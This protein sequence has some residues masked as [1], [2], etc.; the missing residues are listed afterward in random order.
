[1]L[2]VCSVFVLGTPGDPSKFINSTGGVT[3]TIGGNSGIGNFSGNVYASNIV[4]NISGSNIT[5]GTISANRIDNSIARVSDIDSSLV[6]YYN[7]INNFTQNLTNNKTCFYNS[8][9]LKIQCDYTINFT[10]TND[11]I[12]IGI[13]RTD[14]QKNDTDIRSNLSTKL[15]QSQA[16]ALYYPLGSNPS[17]Y[18]T[19]TNLNANISSLSVVYAT[20]INLNNNISALSSIYATITNLNSN[21]S[22]L[23]S[24]Y[25]TITNLN[26]NVTSLRNM[27]TSLANN[28][29]AVSANLSSNVT[30]LRNVDS[31]LAQ[32]ISYRAT[33]G[34]CSDGFVLMNLTNTSAQCVNMTI[35]TTS[36][37]GTY[38]S[39]TVIPIVIVS[40]G[41]VTGISSVTA[42]GD[43][44]GITTAS[45]SGLQGGCTSGVCTLLIN[46]TWLN[47]NYVTLTNFN[48]NMSALSLNITSL[49]GNLS[50]N[51]T[52][53]NTLYSMFTGNT[54]IWNA[55]AGTGNC[56][57]GTVV[58]NT[59][60]NGV[61]CVSVG[62]V[63]TVTS[64]STSNPIL[65]GTITSSG[66][67]S[68]NDSYTDIKYTNKTYVDSQNS[69]MKSYSDTTF[70][71]KSGLVTAVGNWTADK[72]SYNTTTQ[73]GVLY[74]NKTYVDSQNSSMK[75][76]VDSVNTAQNNTI[77]SVVT[78]LSNEASYRSGNDSL[79]NTQL[80]N[81][82]SRLDGRINATNGNL[83]SN[84]SAL[85]NTDSS[86]A[87][88][89][90]NVK[91]NLSSNSTRMDNIQNNLSSNATK[92]NSLQSSFDGNKTI[93]DAKAGTNTSGCGVGYVVQNVSTST[94]GVSVQC[95]IAT[96][97][98]PYQN[99]AAGWTN[100]STY[101]ITDLNVS[102]NALINFTG[103]NGSNTS[104][105]AGL[106]PDSEKSMTFRTTQSA[107]FYLGSGG[108]LNI[109]NRSGSWID[110]FRETDGLINTRY[111]GTSA[112]WYSAFNL[113]NN[114]TNTLSSLATNVSL[115]LDSDGTINKSQVLNWDAAC[116]HGAIVAINE[117]ATYC[118]GNLVSIG[119]NVSFNNVNVTGSFNATTSVNT[120]LV[121]TVDVNVTGCLFLSG[122]TSIGSVSACE[123]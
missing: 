108:Y 61:Q 121:N 51:A 50:G 23:S 64:V 37:S 100:D 73:N 98:V 115:K 57:S 94:G 19:V 75:S 16:D 45:D 122:N 105:Y 1:M 67:I 28:I 118:D 15:N 91:N 46:S 10:D 116:P 101:T 92:L 3:A 34:T 119:E 42:T 63:G 7:S 120:P 70:Q 49:Q 39:A 40:N 27:D 103:N 52:L 4:G 9:S 18:A 11:T 47:V 68:F 59:T 104:I 69:S 17:N 99:S 106:N 74:T 48:N 88:N 32:N 114:H 112:N 60:T 123:G 55:K 41:R 35:N 80:V 65:G 56:G 13:E 71:T 20:I 93:W 110:Y 86:L 22:A 24:T 72:S 109:Y 38:G 5:S 79:I 107:D 97:S 102:V 87:T 90:T 66:T 36:T 8:S 58:Q 76:Y 12:A 77:S 83:T 21:I 85:Q 54:S 78:N 31:S 6:G 14:R 29:S 44:A 30:S 96:S 53:L 84:V 81:N 89:I 111:Y 113:A 33:N 62:G 26:N 2:V 82:A 117:T 25:S 95:V 43:I